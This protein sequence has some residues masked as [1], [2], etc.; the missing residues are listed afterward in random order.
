MRLFSTILILLLI[1]SILISCSSSPGKNEGGTLSKNQVLKLN[2]DADLFVLDGKVYSTGIRWVEE[3]ELTKG[4]QIGKIS[5]GMAS[6]LPIGA[7]IFAPEERRDILIVEYDGKE[8]RYLL[9]V[10]E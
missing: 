9:Q 1:P 3:E 5:E 4:E 6:K 10:G 2:P 7:K 8:K